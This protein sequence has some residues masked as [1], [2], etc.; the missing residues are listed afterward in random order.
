MTSIKDLKEADVFKGL[1]TRQLQLFA[2]H[3]REEQFKAGEVIFPQGSPAQKLFILL[4]GEVALGIEAKGKIDIT[5]YLVAK[6][7]E[8]FGL[9]SLIK[10]HQ[11]NVTAI[12]NKKTRALSIDGEVLRK[13]MK[14]NSKAGIKIMERVTEIYYRRLNS[15][16]AMITNL[17]KLFK[18]QSGK[19]KLMET[20]YEA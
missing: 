9:S 14:Q 15:A 8:A 2:K 3:F 10:P 13:L 4:D 20:Y 5:A 16:R 11:N 7:G 19:S 1:N 17:F 12:C 6:K 18:V